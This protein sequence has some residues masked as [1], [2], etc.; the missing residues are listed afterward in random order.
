MPTGQ[1]LVGRKLRTERFTGMNK[2]CLTFVTAVVA[3]TLLAICAAAK[4]MP[5]KPVAPV[6]ADGIRYSADGDGKDEYVIATEVASNN[7]LWKVKVFH[8]AINS[9]LEEDVQW[10]FIT[11]LKLDGDSLLVKDEKSR[12]YSIDRTTKRVKKLLWCGNTFSS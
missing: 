9:S 10:V 8:T 12:C 4:R 6:I 5:P 7:V 1:V 3:L 11:D 2:V